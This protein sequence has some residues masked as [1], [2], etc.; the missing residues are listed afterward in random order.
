M[1]E[2]MMKKHSLLLSLRVGALTST[3]LAGIFSPAGAAYADDTQT[4]KEISEFAAKGYD[5]TSGLIKIIKFLTNLTGG[6]APESVTLKNILQA[7]ITA[8]NIKADNDYLEA[9]QNVIPSFNRLADQIKGRFAEQDSDVTIQTSEFGK[10]FL[11][12][13]LQNIT[14][15]LDVLLS[16]PE[17]VLQ[18]PANT[19]E[20]AQRVAKLLPAY[21]TV[22][23]LWVSSYR[24]LS[25]IDQS[26][27]PVQEK[28]IYRQLSIAQ[29]VLLSAVGAYV[30]DAY[31]CDK[32]QVFFYS[33]VGT[34]NGWMFNR[35]LYAY[36]HI[37]AGRFD[38]VPALRFE[39]YQKEPIAEKALDSL[40][41]IT[42]TAPAIVLARDA[43]IFNLYT[44]P[45][46]GPSKASFASCVLGSILRVHS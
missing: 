24:M 40:E 23:P 15:K 45:N 10:T 12:T 39:Q 1:R 25:G 18:L 33:P 27:K 14:D 30:L 4:L 2:N 32:E 5:Y 20:N 43:Y 38:F 46:Y 28:W 22:I 13:S 26:F 35:P 36:Y 8:G 3:L 17:N 16:H 11:A 41:R 9:V 31:E 21:L 19:E 44:D 6:P 37:H 34:D 42:K 7:A 29:Q